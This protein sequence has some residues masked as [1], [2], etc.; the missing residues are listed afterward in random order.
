M[1]ALNTRLRRSP[2]TGMRQRGIA[3]IEFALVF[4]LL[5]IALYG[6]VTFGA[7]FY[8]QQVIS[9]AAEDGA[10]AAMLMQQPPTPDS[11]CQA[12]LASLASSLVPR[13]TC[14]GSDSDLTSVSL[15]GCSLGGASCAVTVVYRYKDNPILPPVF[16][17]SLPDKL[18]STATV[19]LKAS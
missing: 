8:T 16:D 15:A 18:Q 17:I 3:A 2:H 7:I 11:V 1:S 10:R 5:F 13:F 9:R 4:M 12:I 19:A 6:V 14:P